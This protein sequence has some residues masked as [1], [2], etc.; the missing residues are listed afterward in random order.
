MNRFNFQI[1]QR[2]WA[3]AKLYWFGNEKK[4]AL[5]LLGLLFILLIAYTQ[6]SVI[7]T[8]KQGEIISSLSAKDVERFWTTIK[9]FLAVLVAYVP[10]FAGFRY[11]QNILGNYW[12][13]WLTH[14]FI[15]RYFNNR[16]FYEL[17]NFDKN[18]DNPDQRIA[19]DIKGFTQDS[20]VFLLIII[21]SIFQVIAFSFVLWNISSNLVYLLFVYAIIGTLITTGFFGKKLVKINFDQ[22]KKEANF[23]FGLVR[24][25]ENSEAI[26]FY[27]GENQESSSLKEKFE[28][29]FRNFNSLV[30]WREL[31]LGL[32]SNTY[33]FFPYILPAIIVAP[34]VF[35][36]E[37]E[38][39]KV[40]ESQIAF[41]RV[42]DSLN[43]IVANFQSLTAFVAGV[44]R[45]S[46]FD[47]YLEQPKDSFNNGSSDR[48]TIDTYQRN[49]LAIQNLTLKTP[50]Y[51][52]TLVKNLS[53]ELN[54]GEGL[55]IMGASGC[56]KSSLLRAIAGLWNSGT[57][58]IYRPDLDRMLFLPQKPYMILGNLR[59]Q[60]TYPHTDLK[61]DDRELYEILKQVNLANLTEQFG[62]LET[63]K[64]WADV[65]SLG[66]QQRLAFARILINKPLYAILDEATSA[67]DVNNEASLYSHLQQTQ[68]TFI[69]VGHRPTLIK[70]HKSIL[71]MLEG[72]R[73]QIQPVS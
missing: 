38:V 18:I 33:Q 65:L 49:H 14:H 52:R 59:Q 25:R 45:L 46:S 28:E 5:T 53:L 63:E 72:D 3:I 32:F 20:L 22:L 56:G 12:R 29:A 16:S 6:L 58:T 9:I 7:L 48:P 57:G 23:R 51:Q 21:N 40:T 71:T 8:Q 30:L 69:S 42:F 2:F 24:I 43:L 31:F 39:G 36:G 44:D 61:I 13:K 73:W 70:Y 27:Q 10:L 67:L 41:A 15:D 47:E 66:E 68:T 19:E 50:N 35:S 62:G 11:V 34:S 60:L 37:F 26:A 4:G 1:F 17:G 55:L 64:D 54:S